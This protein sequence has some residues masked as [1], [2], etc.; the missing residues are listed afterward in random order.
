M[1][2]KTEYFGQI[3]L[4]T[5]LLSMGQYA[6]VGLAKLAAG[7]LGTNT[8]V[9]GF[10]CTPTTPAS[11]NVLVTPGEVYQIENLEQSTW[12]APGLSTDTHNIL[13]QGY[14]LDPATFG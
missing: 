11:L 3:V 2:R 7:V 9:N 13:K 6:M 1:H 14:I 5:D 4:D 10:T 8:I 12:G